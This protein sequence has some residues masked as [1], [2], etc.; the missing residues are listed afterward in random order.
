MCHLRFQMII[1]SI[2]LVFFIT[3]RRG[4]ALEV[5][6]C[7]SQ[8]RILLCSLLHVDRTP[9]P[10]NVHS[11]LAE[12]LMWSV[13]T[14]KFKLVCLQVNNMQ[15]TTITKAWKT[16][17]VTESDC[18]SAKLFLAWIQNI[19]SSNLETCQYIYMVH[20]LTVVLV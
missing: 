8:R 7:S 15:F 11:F 20:T 6:L 19:L 16:L 4:R 2:L 3:Y 12:H 17:Y 9:S 5:I 13:F 14:E 1:F 18:P 10:Q